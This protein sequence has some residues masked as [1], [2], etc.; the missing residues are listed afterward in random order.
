MINNDILIFNNI[1]GSQAARQP[2]TKAA[3]HSS[4]LLATE[5]TDNWQ[6]IIITANQ[7]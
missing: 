3:N 6:L 2:A 7:S 4:Q 1:A 5:T